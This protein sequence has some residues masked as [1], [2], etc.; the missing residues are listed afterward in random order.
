M[1]IYTALQTL[2][3]K[4]LFTFASTV[5]AVPIES[6]QVQPASNLTIELYNDATVQGFYLDEP[7]ILAG[8]KVDASCST[9]D[10]IAAISN[11]ITISDVSAFCSVI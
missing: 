9:A 1:V 3:S 8:C 4:H 7:I 6:S 2:T 11:K 10:F 5:S